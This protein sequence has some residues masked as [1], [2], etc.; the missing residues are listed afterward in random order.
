MED[1]AEVKT[2]LDNEYLDVPGGLSGNDDAGQMSAWYVLSAL[3]FYPVCP[4]SPY[5]IIG[6]PTFD[7]AHIGRFTIKAHHVSHENIYIQSATYNGQPYTHNYITYEMLKGDGVL[8]FQMGPK[9][10]TEW[11]S[12]TEDC[13]PDL[14][15]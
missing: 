5:Y 10:N 11:G 7:E 3:G 1:T 12:K 6:T 8:E 14:M 2:I 9:P 13:P 4:V 15:K